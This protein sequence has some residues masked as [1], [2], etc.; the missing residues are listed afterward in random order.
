MAPADSA[1]FTVTKSVEE[2]TVGEF[3]E[4]SVTL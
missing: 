1:G 3:V 2:D 4:V